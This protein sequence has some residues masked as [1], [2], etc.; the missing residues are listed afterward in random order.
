MELAKSVV[1]E[2]LRLDPP[3]ENLWGHARED[4]II[5]SHDT[6][7]KVKKGEMLVGYQPVA[8]RDEKIFRNAEE[9][10]P[11]RFV[12]DEGKKLLEHV[13]WSNGPGTDEPVPNNK[14]CA[15]KNM[16]LLV[17]RL[18]IAHIFLRYDTF[19]A[20]FDGLLL[21]IEP[22]MVIN[23]VSKASQKY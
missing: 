7:Y 23:S 9:F 16:V 8:M 19:S 15:G 3:V 18:F 13:Y 20:K 5:E 22:K 17:G 12:S 6:A 10:I 2:A 1:W 4:L 21:G 14:Q 11:D